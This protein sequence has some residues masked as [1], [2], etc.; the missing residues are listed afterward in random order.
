MLM[1]S[2]IAFAQ[3]EKSH[4]IMRYGF[5]ISTFYNNS[6][7]SVL[8]YDKDKFTGDFGDVYMGIETKEGMELT[9]NIFSSCMNMNYSEQMDE[10]NRIAGIGLHLGK[11]YNVVHNISA[12]LFLGGGLLTS[13][14]QIHYIKKDYDVD[15]RLGYYV[16]IN[17]ALEYSVNNWAA[18]GVN[19][20]DF[21]GTL[22]DKDLP[23]KFS[24]LQANHVNDV[25]NYSLSMF[26][27]F[28]L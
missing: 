4:F 19:I 21:Y 12:G 17:L 14:A 9:L 11:M 25:Y 27:K 28:R 20:G 16:R 2:S 8:K 24:S 3:Q 18:F 10:I 7:I 22:K 26:A 13:D 15:A 6:G 5:G 23:K 1:I